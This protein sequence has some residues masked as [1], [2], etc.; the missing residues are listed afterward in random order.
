M[1]RVGGVWDLLGRPGLY[2][3]GQRLLVRPETAV[4]RRGTHFSGLGATATRV[5]DIGAG[6]ANFLARHAAAG[7]LSYVGIEPDAAHVATARATYGDRV[8]M[9]HG[10]T[11]D[12]EAAALGRFDLIIADG[13][14]HHLTD[15][16]ADRLAAFA[17]DHLA[18]GGSFVCFDPVRRVGQSPVARLAM[19][20]DRGAR[21][22]T[23]DDYL[24]IL[25]GAFGEDVRG[26]VTGGRLRIPYD[27]FE[28]VCGSIGA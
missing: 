12:A 14:L 24:R 27:H 1:Q 19:A 2:A 5:L 22:R 21:I 28:A 6:P 9:I 4:R 8:R 13:V 23:A 11:D 3:L 7:S 16:Q 25:R 15:D 17:H 26:E 18:P 10:T 20:L